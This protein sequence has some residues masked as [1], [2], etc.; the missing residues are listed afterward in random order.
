M[1]ACKRVTSMSTSSRA[2]RQIYIHNLIFYLALLTEPTLKQW[3][4]S[5]HCHAATRYAQLCEQMVRAF[6]NLTHIDGNMFTSYFLSIL[7]D[8]SKVFY[9]IY[10]YISNLLQHTHTYTKHIIKLMDWEH[11]GRQIWP[12]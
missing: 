6:N 2:H 5:S 4:A 8:S 7:S 11:I 12:S 3:M 10:N 9:M 1:H